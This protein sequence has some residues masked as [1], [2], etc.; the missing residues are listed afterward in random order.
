MAFDWKR[1][2][3]GGAK[4]LAGYL[5]SEIEGKRKSAR[6]ERMAEIKHAFALAENKDRF[7]YGVTLQGIADAAATKRAK[8][9]DAAATKRAKEAATTTSQHIMER[10]RVYQ[11]LMLLNITKGSEEWYSK[12]A[13]IYNK[14][15]QD[16]QNLPARS[17]EME[18]YILNFL[19]GKRTPENYVIAQMYTDKTYKTPEER[20]FIGA[21]AMMDAILKDP[22]GTKPE[23]PSAF[24]T[25]FKE[26]AKEM[27][28]EALARDNAYKARLRR[29]RGQQGR[30]P[31]NLRAPADVN[32]GRNMGSD[33]RPTRTR[34][35]DDGP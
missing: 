30:Q 11:E 24:G 35:Y 14:E 32:S 16:P 18:H 15:R 6:E 10:N 22:L 27:T 31:S 7:D 1:G 26:L 2:V 33:R 29:E 9:A 20:G 3:S 25:M 28:E 17:A 4:A 8:E 34:Y 19:D 21:Q 5:G 13:E 12:A 23:S